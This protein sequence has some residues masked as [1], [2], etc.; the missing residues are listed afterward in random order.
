MQYSQIARGQ[1]TAMTLTVIDKI[2]NAFPEVG[3]ADIVVVL[4]HV[5]AK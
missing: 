2:L 1:T 3:I 5:P 4:K